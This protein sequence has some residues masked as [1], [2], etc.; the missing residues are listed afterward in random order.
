MSFDEG[1]GGPFGHRFNPRRL[2]DRHIRE[3]ENLG[4]LGRLCLPRNVDC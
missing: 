1:W 2:M 4:S 3:A